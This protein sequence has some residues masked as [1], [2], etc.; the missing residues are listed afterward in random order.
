VRLLPYDNINYQA[1]TRGGRVM[2]HILGN[3]AVFKQATSNVGDVALVGA[4]GAAQFG[5]GEDAQKAALG[6]AA[7]GLISKL[8]SAATMTAAD[9]RMWDNLPQYLSFAALNLE[10][11]VHEA[12]LTFFDA[13][14]NAL[15][16]RTQHFTIN[17]PEK[18]NAIAA[19]P[20]DVVV[21]RSELP[22]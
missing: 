20:G 6:L 13:H 4:L 10:P 9:T 14:G 5:R 12:T 7:V 1:T 16:N 18:S 11:G 22:H 21:F 15:S 3:K 17:V 2:D 8:A 19:G